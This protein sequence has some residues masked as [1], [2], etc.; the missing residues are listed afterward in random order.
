MK[1]EGGPDLEP[2]LTREWLIANGLGRYASGTVS[3]VG[4]AA[5]ELDAARGAS[6]GDRRRLR[7]FGAARLDGIESCP[8]RDTRSLIVLKNTCSGGP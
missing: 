5:V 4:Q 6:R 2:L 7:L 1:W 3:G 8:P